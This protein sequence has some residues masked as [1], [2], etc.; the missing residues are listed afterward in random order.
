RY[1]LDVFRPDGGVLRIERAVE[2]VA[3]DGDEKANAEERATHNFR[4]M[5]PDWKWNG[6]G[7]PGTKPPYRAILTG[8]D[9][10]IYVQL[11]QPGERI[12]EEEIETSSDPGAA[13]PNRWREPVVFDVFE[14]DGTYLGQ[15]RPPARFQASPQPVFDR[16]RVWA[17]VTDEMDVEYLTRFRLGDEV[18][19]GRD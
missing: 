9:G 18:G 12:P 5:L 19:S 14:E 4:R 2:P 3:V 8:R 13:P 16:E 10:R 17:V 1:A 7:I 15:I 6:P 11:W